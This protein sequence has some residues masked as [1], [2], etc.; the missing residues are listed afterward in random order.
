MTIHPNSITHL[1]VSYQL[2]HLKQ[3]IIPFT[4][5]CKDKEKR[6]F[7]VRVRFSDHCYS[8]ALAEAPPDGAY[9][10]VGPG[11]RRMLNLDRHAMSQFLPGLMVG[12][13]MKPGTALAQTAHKN[14]STYFVS[15]PTPMKPGEKYY[16]FL[17]LRPNVSPTGVSS[18]WL[19][20]FV[21][22]AYPR[23]DAVKTFARK[24]FGRIV[25]EMF[26]AK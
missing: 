17:S 25:E 11:G 21:E 12:I 20:M 22:S 1:G 24:P 4:W 13:L 23:S 18:G 14:W 6:Q 19:D 3:K 8:E 7:S 26:L 9:C 16:V 2:T 15:L 5:I 10:T